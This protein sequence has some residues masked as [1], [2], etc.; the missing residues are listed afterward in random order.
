VKGTGII[1]LAFF[2][3]RDLALHRWLSSSEDGITLAVS[4]H[5]TKS[6]GQ[7]ELVRHGMSGEAAKSKCVYD[8]CRGKCVPKHI[9]QLHGILKTKSRTTLN[10]GHES[11]LLTYSS[12]GASTLPNQPPLLGPPRKPYPICDGAGAPLTECLCQLPESVFQLAIAP[13]LERPCEWDECVR[14]LSVTRTTQEIHFGNGCGH[15][16]RRVHPAVSGTVSRSTCLVAVASRW[17]YRSLS[18]PG[19]GSKVDG[20]SQS[21][22][23]I[24][25]SY[26]VGIGRSFRPRMKI[27]LTMGLSPITA[28]T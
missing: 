1:V 19:E 18:R 3:S 16:P 8:G 13:E 26:D 5:R 21:S 24:G 12:T 10:T 22:S 11:C 2:Q 23:R 27:G 28:D 14:Q 15:L 17:P 25:A 6:V 7:L 4:Y 9:Y 20:T